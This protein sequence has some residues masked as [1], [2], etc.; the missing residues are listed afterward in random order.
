MISSAGRGFSDLVELGAV[1]SWQAAEA[2]LRQQKL[3]HAGG[4]GDEAAGPH[5]LLKM[6]LQELL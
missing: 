1:R 6:Q 2:A 5:L 4:Q 3:V